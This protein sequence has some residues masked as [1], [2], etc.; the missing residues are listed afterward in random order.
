MAHPITRTQAIAIG[1]IRS[2][3]AFRCWQRYVSGAAEVLG[4]IQSAE[5]RDCTQ[6]Q[7]IQHAGIAMS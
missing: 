2:R 1:C 5:S 4:S 7:L 3:A 6:P